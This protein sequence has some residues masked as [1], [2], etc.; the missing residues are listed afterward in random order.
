MRQTLT[1]ID[2]KE[3]LSYLQY[4]GDDQ[5]IHK[6]ID[7]CISTILQVARPR[8]IYKQYELRDKQPLDCLVRFV[9]KD[10]QNLLAS[11][12]H[13]ILIAATIGQRVDVT[14]RNMQLQDMGKALIFDACANAAIEQ[15]IEDAQTEIAGKLLLEGYYLTDRYSCGYG[16]LPIQLQANFLKEL[17]TQKQIGLYCNEAFV[18]SPTKSV[19]AIIGISKQ[20]QPALIKGCASCMLYEHCVRRK[21]GNPCVKE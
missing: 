1:H 17:N 2:K 20:P 21:A 4:Q 11:S 19:T 16:D 5:G 6:D 14:L 12:S 15:V 3:V 13:C 8:I 7:T 18:L 9:G 10:I